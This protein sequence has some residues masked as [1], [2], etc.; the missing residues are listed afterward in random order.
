MSEIERLEKE[1]ELAT[2]RLSAEQ[3]SYRTAKTKLKEAKVAAGIIKVDDATAKM[4]G[5]IRDKAE[6]FKSVLCK[7]LLKALAD[8]LEGKG[9][10]ELLDMDDELFRQQN[11]KLRVVVWYENR[12]EWRFGGYAVAKANLEYLSA[13]EAAESDKSILNVELLRAERKWER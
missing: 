10:S 6:L 9:G 4:C 12:V 1:V 7:R 3:V 11:A 13:V 5:E 8:A 2:V